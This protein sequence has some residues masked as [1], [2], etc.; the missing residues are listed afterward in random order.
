MYLLAE[1]TLDLEAPA[2]SHD[3]RPEHCGD[4]NAS[5]QDTVQEWQA[6]L[7]TQLKWNGQAQATPRGDLSKILCK[8]V[9]LEIIFLRKPVVTLFVRL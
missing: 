1:T 3:Q 9:C 5:K 2:I 7:Q 8:Q 6:Q 4:N